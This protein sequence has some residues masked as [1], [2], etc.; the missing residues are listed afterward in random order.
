MEFCK[1]CWEIKC[2]NINIFFKH[3]NN[4]DNFKVKFINYCNKCLYKKKI[5]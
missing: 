2:T 3:N 5:K 4:K 1:T